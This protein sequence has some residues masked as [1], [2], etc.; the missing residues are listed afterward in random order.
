MNTYTPPA[1]MKSSKCGLLMDVP[2][3]IKNGKIKINQCIV[4]Q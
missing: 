1:Y 4:D 3:K 2:V